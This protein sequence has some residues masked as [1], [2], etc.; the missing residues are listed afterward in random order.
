MS[1]VKYKNNNLQI[2]TIL[3]KAKQIIIDVEKALK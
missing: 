1:Y 2:D 3:G